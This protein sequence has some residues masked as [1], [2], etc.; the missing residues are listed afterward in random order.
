MARSKEEKMRI[1]AALK[2]GLIVYSLVT[3]IFLLNMA[4]AETTGKFV[5]PND[6]IRVDGGTFQMGATD[7]FSP[8][9]PIHGITV[10][11]FYIGKYEVTQQEWQTV[12]S[13]NPSLFIGEKLPVERISWYDAVEF[14]NKKSEKDGLNPC[15]TGTGENIVCNFDADGYRLPTEAEWEFAASGGIQG[16]NYLFSGGNT[17]DEVAWYDNNSLDKTHPVGLKNA[18][19]LGVHDMSGN[20]REWCWDRYDS[21]YYKKSPTE[22]PRGP[23]VGKTR[24]YRGGSACERKISLRCSARFQLPPES[25]QYDLGLRIIK[26][27]MDAD[28]GNTAKQ[29]PPEGMVLVKGG[30]FNMGNNKGIG[31]EKVLHDVTVRSFL[32]GK[33]EVTQDQWKEIIGSNPS[34]RR[35]NKTPINFVDWYDAIEYCNKRSIKEG[36]TPC[37]SGSGEAISCNFDANGY[38]LPTE[39][40]WEYAA[41]GGKHSGNF[42]YSGSNNAGDVAWYRDNYFIYF[43]PVGWKNP[44]ELGIYDMSGNMWELCWD[45]YNYDYYSRSPKENP[46]GPK[47][48]LRRVTRGGG[49]LNAEDNQLTTYRNAFEPYR[50]GF[51]IGFRVVRTLE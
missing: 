42:K 21:E 28:N 12:M 41:R 22:N 1:K 19:S 50:G 43:Q 51:H 25:K 24:T 40:E 32:I 44:N 46:T 36:L 11:S 30:T 14:C 29:N 48:G 37:Y 7:I 9:E 49:W 2:T 3:V 4:S 17:A 10:K 33:Y 23:E 16:Q 45:R 34:F 18:N 15:Y 35:G 27:A 31:G 47:T 39:A 26:N 6:M 8:E 20:V 13:D 5:T 38:R